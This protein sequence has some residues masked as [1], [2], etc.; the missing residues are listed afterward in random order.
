MDFLSEEERDQAMLFTAQYLPRLLAAIEKGLE[1]LGLKTDT[2]FSYPDETRGWDPN[3]ANVDGDG[4]LNDVDPNPEV[5]DGN[6]GLDPITWDF[7]EL[8]ENPM[9]GVMTVAG[10][11]PATGEHFESLPLVSLP[12]ASM[13]LDLNLSHRSR[14]LLDGPV[15]KGWTMEC[16]ARI[17]GDPT[18]EV[19]LIDGSGHAGTFTNTGTGDFETPPGWYCTLEF[20]G[21]EYTVTWPGKLRWY[22]YADGR[23][24]GVEN[25]NGLGWTC[26]Y[27]ADW[28]LVALTDTFGRAVTLDYYSTGRLFRLSDWYFEDGLERETLLSYGD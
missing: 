24:V 20:N 9:N 26:S 16:F 6:G 13:S 10:V 4:Y 19:T 3:N 2:R 23:L 14:W 27:D 21:I 7:E 5:F 18:V 12:V 25:R 11:N 17:I 28:N 8:A 15:G 1:A 22:F